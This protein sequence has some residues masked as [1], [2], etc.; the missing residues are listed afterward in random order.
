M[1]TRE[2]CI[3]SLLADPVFANVDPEIVEKFVSWTNT[4][5]PVFAQIQLDLNALFLRKLLND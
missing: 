5:N 2:Y 1:K 4:E 3:E